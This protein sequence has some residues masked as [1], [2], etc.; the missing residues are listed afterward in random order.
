M[1]INL[2]ILIGLI[3]ILLGLFACDSIPNF[4]SSNSTTTEEISFSRITGD[5]YFNGVYGDLSDQGLLARMKAAP[6]E[7]ELIAQNTLKA[8]HIAP[9]KLDDYHKN[10]LPSYITEGFFN[11]DGIA[12]II[13]KPKVENDLGSL[14]MLQLRNSQNDLMNFEVNKSYRDALVLSVGVDDNAVRKVILDDNYPAYILNGEFRIRYKEDGEISFKGWWTWGVK[15][16]LFQRDGYVYQII[17]RTIPDRV[18]SYDTE[19]I[20]MANSWIE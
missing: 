2:R 19:L 16:I 1:K 11:S 9:T 14:A 8:I 20:L 12:S 18:N 15:R 13:Y 17:V 10:A 6:T 5:Q 3:P 4:R 7:R